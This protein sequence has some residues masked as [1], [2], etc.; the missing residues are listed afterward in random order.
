MAITTLDGAIAGAR[1]PEFITKA[2]TGTLVAG[3]PRSLWYLAGQPGA[4]TAGSTLAGTALTAPVAG[5]INFTNTG[6]GAR[7]YVF[8]FVASVTQPGM[9][10]LADRLWHNGGY[11]ITS[12]GA[13][14]INSVAFPARDNNE[15]TNGEGVILGLEVA[16]ATGAGTPTITVSY[17]NSGNTASRTATNTIAT[18]ATAA[19]GSFFPIGLQAGDT[20]V[21]SVQTLTLS[22]TWTS[23]TISLV[24]YRPI[25]SLEL[26][27]GNTSN[28]VDAI[29]SGFPELA[30]GSVPF[31]I[32]IPSTTTTSN[33]TGSLVYTQG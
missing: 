31:L 24:A 18:T 1:P 17:T 20:G 19:A 7:N 30:E 16:T 15:S 29:T 4:G 21:R 25:V 8:R 22:A 9:I 28:A 33:V 12:T 26:P 6:T 2:V 10:I 14:T 11:T 3:Q 32:F 13:Q 5:Q 27:I 23:G